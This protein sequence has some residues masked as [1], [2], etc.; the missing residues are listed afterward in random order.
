M[1]TK[2]WI[3]G[4]TDGDGCF[5]IHQNWN[6]TTKNGKRILY[7]QKRPT[8]SIAQGEKEILKKIRNYFTKLGVYGRVWLKK[9]GTT[10]YEYR[11]VGYK[12]CK[13]IANFFRGKLHTK[14]KIKRFKKWDLIIRRHYE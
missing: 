6:N 8:F 12:N 3:I 13:I 10:N 11:T 7:K 9:I 2:N 4:F 5:T 1:L 14:N